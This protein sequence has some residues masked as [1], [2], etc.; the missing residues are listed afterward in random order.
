M[1]RTLAYL[2]RSAE[3]HQSL[4]S[5]LREDKPDSRRLFQEGQVILSLEEDIEASLRE[6]RSMDAGHQT[7]CSLHNNFLIGV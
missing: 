3:K 5:L 2:S 4:W 7:L 1:K 6:L